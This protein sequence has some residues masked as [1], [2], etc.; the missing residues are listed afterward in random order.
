[1]MSFDKLRFILQLTGFR[2]D[3]LFEKYISDT[4]R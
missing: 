2:K 4:G 3:D 1:M